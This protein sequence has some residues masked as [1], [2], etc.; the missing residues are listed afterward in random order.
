MHNELSVIESRTFNPL[1]SLHFLDLSINKIKK[2]GVFGCLLEIF[3][4][5]VLCIMI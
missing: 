4:P 1:F 2:S 3:K 5:Y